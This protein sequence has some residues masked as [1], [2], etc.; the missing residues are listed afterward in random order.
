MK[1]QKVQFAPAGPSFTRA[2]T[3]SHVLQPLPGKSKVC[4]SSQ[5]T[6]Q[7]VNIIRGGIKN[8]Q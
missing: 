8:S 4:L 2:F 3:Q 5:P 1:G 7:G 6:F